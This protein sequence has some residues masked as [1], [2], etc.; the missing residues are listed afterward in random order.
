MPANCQ[1]CTSAPKNRQDPPSLPR[2]P[3]TSSGPRGVA[4]TTGSCGENKFRL[5]SQVELDVLLT[6][7]GYLHRRQPPNQATKGRRKS[8]STQRIWRRE[9]RAWTSP[10]LALLGRDG[11]KMAGRWPLTALY[12][13]LASDR[14]YTSVRFSKKLRNALLVRR[15]T[16]Q[17]L[18]QCG[19]RRLCPR[20]ELWPLNGSPVGCCRRLSLSRGGH[21]FLIFPGRMGFADPAFRCFQQEVALQ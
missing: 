1:H 8:G 19:S 3:V 17:W 5:L 15:G 2:S 12:L 9:S 20:V 21:D 11:P 4:L 18:Y 14:V 10:S 6:R 16:R 13:F 7:G